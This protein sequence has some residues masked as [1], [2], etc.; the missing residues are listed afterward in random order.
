MSQI[1]L[2]NLE[3][4]YLQQIECNYFTRVCLLYAILYICGQPLVISVTTNR[5]AHIFTS[6]KYTVTNE[7]Y[8]DGNIHCNKFARVKVNSLTSVFRQTLLLNEGTF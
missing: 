8:R 1:I 6:T 5:L 7:N 2:N 4:Q 3:F